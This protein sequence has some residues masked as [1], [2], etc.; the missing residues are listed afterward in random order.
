[1]A[2]LK[3]GKLPIYL[4]DPEY[5][6]L[7]LRHFR[8]DRTHFDDKNQR[9]M[10]LFIFIFLKYFFM[11]IIIFLMNYCLFLQTIGLKLILYIFY[12]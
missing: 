11:F 2:Y 4:R 10:S 3:N 7:S 12:I 9:Q 1:M 6:K 8:P 5:A